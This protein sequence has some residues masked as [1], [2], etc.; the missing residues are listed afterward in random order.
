MAKKKKKIKPV[1]WIEAKRIYVEG[2]ID[3]H[4]GSITKISYADV[5]RAVGAA[6]S[7]ITRKANDRNWERERLERK[8][9]KEDAINKRAADGEIVKLGDIKITTI[10]ALTKMV[11][12]FKEQVVK[13]EIKLTPK[14]FILVAPFLFSLLETVYGVEGDETG[15][16]IIAD[17]IRWDEII[18]AGAYK[19]RE[20]MEKDR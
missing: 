13:G 3:K 4:D 7:T 15:G 12:D 19:I 1:D 17:G 16:V 5:A 6:R 14:E 11:E 2:G 10:Q 20:L 8:K 18:L 9:E